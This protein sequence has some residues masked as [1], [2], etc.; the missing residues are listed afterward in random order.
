[1]TLSPEWIVAIC[2]GVTLAILWTSTVVGGAV[3]L[4]RQFSKLE[5]R[6]LALKEEILADFNLKHEA[7]ETTVKAIEALVMRHDIL[8]NP[9][10]NGTGKHV[11]RHQ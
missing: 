1:M 7:N 9:E 11:S 4:M 3:W 5:R 10:F 2:A 6:M 8:L